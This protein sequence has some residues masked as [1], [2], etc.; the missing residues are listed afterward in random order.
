[1]IEVF[2]ITLLR[3]EWIAALLLIAGL[4]IFM[5][6]RISGLAG[7]TKVVDEP[8]LEAMNKMGRVRPGSGGRNWLPAIIATIIGVAMLGPATRVREEQSFRNLDGLVL[9][10]DMSRSVT[11]GGDLTS[12]VAATRLMLAQSGARS[13]GLVIF[14]GDAYQVSAFTSDLTAIGTMMALLDAETVP[15]PGSRPERGL[16]EASA[17][18]QQ[19]SIIS[20]DVLMIT[21]GGGISDAVRREVET[22]VGSGAR[23]SVLLIPSSAGPVAPDP[24]KVQ[25]LV[26]IGGGVL[27]NIVD[28]SAMSEMLSTSVGAEHASGGF[29]ALNWRDFGRWV[30]LIALFPALALFRKGA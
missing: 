21:D 3:P 11:E 23:V 14:A 15:D 13:V 19:A 24:A 28:T 18:L 4:G 5:A 7:W 17:M 16:Q 8:L 2:G 20:G 10:M 30:L 9:V 1:M 25:E 26:Q 12:A 27:T 22:I 6:P 29:A